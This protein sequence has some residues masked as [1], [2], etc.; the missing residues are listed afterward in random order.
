[1]LVH[2]TKAAMPTIF[3]ARQGILKSAMTA[4]LQHPFR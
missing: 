1:M 4:C 2:L 3:S